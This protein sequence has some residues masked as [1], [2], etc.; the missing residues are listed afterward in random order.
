MTSSALWS[1]TAMKHTNTV[2]R[3][4]GTASEL[5]NEIGDLYYDALANHLHLLAQKM[6]SDSAADAS[7]GRGKLAAELTSKE[8]RLSINKVS[9][10][11]RLEG[12]Q[13]A[14][15]PRRR[16]AGCFICLFTPRMAMYCWLVMTA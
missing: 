9:D 8:R 7:R 14:V 6:A 12:A 16:I 10:G 15:Q 13:K 5:A 11:A 3:Y 2:T 4:P 1:T